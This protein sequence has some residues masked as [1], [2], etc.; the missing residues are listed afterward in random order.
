MSYVDSNG[1]GPPPSCHFLG[2]WALGSRVLPGRAFQT[3]VAWFYLIS[4][5][6][7]R[8]GSDILLTL[9]SLASFFHVKGCDV[10]KS[11]LFGLL[12]S[13]NGKSCSAHTRCIWVVILSW[14]VWDAVIVSFEVLYVALGRVVWEIRGQTRFWSRQKRPLRGA[15]EFWLSKSHKGRLK[16]RKWY[17]SIA[18]V[19]I[20]RTQGHL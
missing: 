18:S 15:F 17:N 12:E 7:S 9:V 13:R 20:Y 8:G 4:Y 10:W 16:L 3:N 5:S 11:V 19:K 14:K 1:R 6:L 2:G